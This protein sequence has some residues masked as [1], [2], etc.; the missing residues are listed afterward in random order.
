MGSGNTKFKLAK[1]NICQK[2]VISI[3]MKKTIPLPYMDHARK[4][5]M[6]I[7]DGIFQ[8]GIVTVGQIL[9]EAR[10]YGISEI[11]GVATA[12][13]RAAKNGPEL[14]EA[15]RKKY[16]F[17]L[18]IIEQNTEGLLGYL[19]AIAYSPKTKVVLDIGG[20]SLQFTGF[21]GSEFKMSGCRC[22]AIE[23]KNYVVRNLFKDQKRL[24]PNPIG[25]NQLDNL[26]LLARQFFKERKLP[27]TPKWW[28]AQNATGIGGVLS[29]GLPHYIKGPINSQKLR[30][31]LEDMINQ[32]DEEI[33][34][35]Y[36]QTTV[37]NFAL[38]YGILQTLNLESITPLR[39]NLTDAL[40]FVSLSEL[41]KSQ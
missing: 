25:T 36:A 20:G 29:G 19:G 24:S 15:I 12:A 30:T 9:K 28:Q 18:R 21:H 10:K 6:K 33:G 38:A 37:T 16:N 5:N 32:T 17:P 22:G 13:F 23:F 31:A 1:V 3:L 35:P 4:N 8:K 2:K 14:I 27:L 39:I 40:L 26:L 34:G 7:P 41:N 11:Q